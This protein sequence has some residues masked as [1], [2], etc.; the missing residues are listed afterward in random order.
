MFS[1][2]LTILII[3]AL[4]SFAAFNNEKIKED[5]LFY[6]AE[7]NSRN[8]YYRF[9]S[10]GLIHADFLHLAFNM[11]ALWSF[12]QYV[13]K[14][15]F[16][17]PNFFGEQGKLF[18]LIL[19]ITAIIVSPLPD[20][21]K[22]KNNFSYRALG[23]SGAVSA[24]I[25]AG[26]MLNPKIS[27]SLL[28]LPIPMPGYIFGVV[29]LVVSAI[30]ARKGGDNIGHGAHLTGAIYGLIFTIITTKVFADYDAVKV[31]LDLILNRY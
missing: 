8:Q 30:L 15:L 2:T 11:L 14:Y 26:I 27:I 29:F 31:F 6:P 28:F 12:G 7:I 20:Y 16:S 17:N 24:V 18:Y 10:Y 3:T 19:Y 21:F 13:E 23:A 1:I 4:I 25:F 5:M 22:H 9:L